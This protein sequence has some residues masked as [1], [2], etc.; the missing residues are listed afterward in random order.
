MKATLK[1]LS[2]GT[3]NNRTNLVLGRSGETGDFEPA[4]KFE[5]LVPGAAS[6]KAGDLLVIELTPKPAEE[7]SP[8]V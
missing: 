6:W 5:L 8:K 2:A 4:E 1:V 3:V 7:E